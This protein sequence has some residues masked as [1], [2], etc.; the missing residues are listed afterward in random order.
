[1]RLPNLDAVAVWDF[2][3]KSLLLLFFLCAII[4]EGVLQDL[5]VKL[6]LLCLLLLSLVF[7]YILLKL[8]VWLGLVAPATLIVS[9]YLFLT[10]MKNFYVSLFIVAIGAAFCIGRYHM[11]VDDMCSTLNRVAD[12][13]KQKGDDAGYDKY[14]QMIKDYRKSLLEPP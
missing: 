1:M 8:D 4:P 11:L 10:N 2:L 14:K 5:A 12:R 9:F 13:V 6:F 3:L 7:I